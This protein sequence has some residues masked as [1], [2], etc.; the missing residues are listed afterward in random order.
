VTLVTKLLERLSK[1]E[2]RVE[3]LD[4]R[5]SKTSRNSSTPH[6]GMGLASGLK[7]YAS[8]VRSHLGVNQTIQ[9]AP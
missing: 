5:L 9:E 8:K 6:L 1:L 2:S 4:G 7:V 3:D